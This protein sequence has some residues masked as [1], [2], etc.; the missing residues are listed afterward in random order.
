M[1]LNKFNQWG[2]GSSGNTVVYSPKITPVTNLLYGG[3]TILS[4]LPVVR[5]GVNNKVFE[6]TAD[7]AISLLSYTSLGVQSTVAT[8][9]FTTYLASSNAVAYHL[10]STDTCL[11]ILLKAGSSFQLIKINDTTGSVTSIGSSFTPTTV[12]NWPSSGNSRGSGF[13]ID[14]VSGHL[15]VVYNGFVHLINK[16][17]GAMVSQDVA[18]TLGAY[19]ASSVYYVTQDGTTGLSSVGQGFGIDPAYR[20]TLTLVSSSYGVLPFKI[21]PHSHSGLTLPI[22]SLSSINSIFSL[23]DNDKVCLS[24]VFSSGG[25]SSSPPIIY[26]RAEFDKFLKSCVAYSSGTI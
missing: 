2:S 15:K 18:V 10:N 21:L 6:A 7:T 13:E 9:T 25:S 22:Q 14:T 5:S 23:I 4:S 20:S 26:S 12:A 1:G 24:Y 17:T 16:S 8:L 3:T 19:L 11:Y